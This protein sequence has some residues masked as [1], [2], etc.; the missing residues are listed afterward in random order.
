MTTNQE[1]SPLRLGGS[2]ERPKTKA[3]RARLCEINTRLNEPETAADVRAELEAERD[4]L[5]PVIPFPVGSLSVN[6]DSAKPTRADLDAWQQRIEERRA[7]IPRPVVPRS[8][9]VLDQEKKRL[10]PLFSKGIVNDE[11]RALAAEHIVVAYS[12][13]GRHISAEDQA[14]LVQFQIDAWTGKVSDEKTAAAI[15][16]IYRLTK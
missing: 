15:G 12:L 11:V 14:A 5:A 3:D 13:P 2:R 9:R 7:G 4:R 1:C 6:E 10:E 16:T 8:V